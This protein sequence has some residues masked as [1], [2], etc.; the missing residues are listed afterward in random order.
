MISQ[1]TQGIQITV[2]AFYRPE[3]SNPLNT[4]FFFTYRITI[5]NQ[6]EHVVQLLSR[7][8]HIFDSNADNYEVQGD[9]VVGFQPTL[10]PNDV[11]EY[12]SGC[13]LTSE[14]G[15]IYGTYLMQR[16]SDGNTFEVKIP[17]FSLVAPMKLN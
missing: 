12:E 3:F 6:S 8:W 4:H 5:E 15:T 11:H 9:G 10:K 1:L 16:V 14:L 7:H 13:E 2:K 17:K